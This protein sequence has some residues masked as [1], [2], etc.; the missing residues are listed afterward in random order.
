MSRLADTATL[1]VLGVLLTSNLSS[2]SAEMQS[3]MVCV[4]FGLLRAP[5]RIGYRALHV[6]PTATLHETIYFPRMQDET[7][8]G[9]DDAKLRLLPRHLSPRLY[10]RQELTNAKRDEGRLGTL[11]S[12]R[13][14]SATARG[15]SFGAL[16]VVLN[17]CIGRAGR[18]RTAFVMGHLAD[19]RSC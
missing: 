2:A 1:G 6:C 14:G 13:T 8:A 10:E 11:L 9:K 18:Q 7:F 19:K 17:V 5:V 4:I 12:F 3:S 16:D 15:I